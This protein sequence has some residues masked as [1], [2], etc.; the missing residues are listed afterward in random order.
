MYGYDHIPS[1]L[2][3]AVTMPGFKN[4][5]R[6]FADRV[7]EALVGMGMYEILNYSFI[8]P[9]WLEKLGL[10]ENDAR[11]NTVSSAI[12]WARIR[13]SCA[14]RWYRRCSIPYRQT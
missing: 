14:R 9:K 12:R 3:N 6:V 4:E 7:K 2:M 13:R 10:S 11:L 5:K 1:T 8:S